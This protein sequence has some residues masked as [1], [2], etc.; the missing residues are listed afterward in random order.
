MKSL[1]YFACEDPEENWRNL[2]LNSTVDLIINLLTHQALTLCDRFSDANSVFW[3]GSSTKILFCY[4]VLWANSRDSIT[5]DV[6]W[7]SAFFPNQQGPV[8]DTGRAIKAGKPKTHCWHWRSWPSVVTWYRIR[9]RISCRYDIA[10]L[11]LISLLALVHSISIFH[12]DL[13]NVN[14]RHLSYSAHYSLPGQCDD[15]RE[16]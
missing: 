14:L 4:S 9:P 16:A 2:G 1:K 11:L 5:L 12:G 13:H 15:R 3:E 8:A 6:E 10:P 7:Y